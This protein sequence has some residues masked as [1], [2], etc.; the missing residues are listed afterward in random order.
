MRNPNVY[1]EDE[2]VKNQYVNEFIWQKANMMSNKKVKS[3]Q[4]HD[5]SN[6]KPVK[7]VPINQS[8]NRNAQSYISPTEVA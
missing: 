1:P 3:I 7:L 8:R 2:F 5:C 4:K 6:A